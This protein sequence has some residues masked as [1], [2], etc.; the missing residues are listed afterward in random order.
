MKIAIL[1]A[2]MSGLVAAQSLFD[3]GIYDIDI[4]DKCVENVSQQKGLHYLHGNCGLSLEP[5]RIENLVLKPDSM[6]VEDY[7]QYSIKVWGEPNVLNNSVRD[8]P[9]STLVYDFKQ[10]YDILI[11]RFGRYI[12]KMDITR[13]FIR[14]CQ[15]EYDCIISTI[16]MQVIFP[17]AVCESE[18]MYVS[19]GLPIGLEFQDCTVAY[20]LHMDV[21][22]Y[23]ASKVFGQCYTEYVNNQPDAVPIKKIKTQTSIITDEVFIKN[24]ILLV[25]RFAEWNRKRLVHEVYSIVKGGMTILKVFGKTNTSL[26][27]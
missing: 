25:G 4:Y 17:D 19:Q 1:G 8:L 7:V 23:R 27:D 13:D 24:K 11:K 21:P 20:N 3:L 18:T 15:L 16:P 9:K 26:I 2:G 10:G 5:R 22:W 6:E 12:Q 14:T